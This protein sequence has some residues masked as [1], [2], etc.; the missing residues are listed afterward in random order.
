MPEVGDEGLDGLEQGASTHQDEGG[1]H[2][3]DCLA[4][5]GTACVGMVQTEEEIHMVGWL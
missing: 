5:G 3:G 4:C 1:V 2:S